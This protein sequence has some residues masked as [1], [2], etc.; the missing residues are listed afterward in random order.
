MIDTETTGLGAMSRIRSISSTGITVNETGGI[1]V[2]DTRSRTFFRQPGMEGGLIRIPTT[3]EVVSLGQGLAGQEV[4]SGVTPDLIDIVAHPEHARSRLTEELTEYMSYDAIAFKNAPF[5]IEQ[6]MTTARS[7]PGYDTDQNLKTAV[8]NLSQRIAHD[9]NFIVDVDF[10]GRLYLERK[11]EQKVQTYVGQALLDPNS[12]QARFIQSGGISLFDNTGAALYSDLT[13][14][15]EDIRGQVKNLLYSKSGFFGSRELF[16]QI[17]MGGRFTPQS[18][19]NIA[20][21]SNI[22]ELIHQEASSG[23]ADANAARKVMQLISQGSHIAETDAYLTGF[24]AKYV[25]TRTTRFFSRKF[26]SSSSI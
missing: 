4:P 17:S 26:G 19:D 21:V 14:M 5:D 16:E 23:S 22:F 18:M 25:Q 3:G 6:L 20:A 11:A 13:T 12:E 1:T 24:Y 7:M 15:P 9:P 8:Q 10:S 2:G